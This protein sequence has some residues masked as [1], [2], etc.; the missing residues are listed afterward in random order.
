MQSGGH[1][2]PYPYFTRVLSSRRC[3][4][5]TR[6]INIH[7]LV[8]HERTGGCIAAAEFVYTAV[9]H[10]GSEASE[11]LTKVKMYN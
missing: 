10:N 5:L 3:E 9:I 4:L 1:D 7:P 2:W 11:L 6:A 8:L